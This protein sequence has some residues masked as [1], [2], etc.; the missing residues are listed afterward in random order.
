MCQYLATELTSM[1]GNPPLLDPNGIYPFEFHRHCTLVSPLQAVISPIIGYI[2]LLLFPSS[3]SA[4]L[5][6]MR[7]HEISVFWMIKPAS[8]SA[9]DRG[10]VPCN[11]PLRKASNVCS[12]FYRG[13]WKFRLPPFDLHTPLRLYLK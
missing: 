8:A 7:L 3:A 9:T 4:T 1:S 10:E 2:F 12:V 11:C 13:M 5:R 6:V